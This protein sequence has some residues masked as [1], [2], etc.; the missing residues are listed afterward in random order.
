MEV[1]VARMFLELDVKHL[2]LQQMEMKNAGQAACGSSCSV[3]FRQWGQ[4]AA[5]WT[6]GLHVERYDS[7]EPDREKSQGMIDD[8]IAGID[9]QRIVLKLGGKLR[10]S[11]AHPPWYQL[12][13]T[14]V[15]HP[16]SQWIRTMTQLHA[17]SCT[18]TCLFAV[19]PHGPKLLCL[20]ERICAVA[21]F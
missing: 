18:I 16:K 19:V 6:P 1:A 3:A 4:T 13:C 5:G 17:N 8:S 11:L 7:T 9:R 12:H 10:N 20:P 15:N 2:P 21:S 14:K